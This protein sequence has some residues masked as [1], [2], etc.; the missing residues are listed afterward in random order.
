[1]IKEVIK[2]LTQIANPPLED[3]LKKHYKKPKFL[4]FKINDSEKLSFR[5]EVNLG[6]KIGTK[7]ETKIRIVIGYDG[8]IWTAFPV[9]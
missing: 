2:N 8:K 4:I 6:K 5:F 7:G 3:G 9:K 1:M